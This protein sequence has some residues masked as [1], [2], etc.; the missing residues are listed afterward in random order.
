[1]ISSLAIPVRQHKRGVRSIRRSAS[2]A[3]LYVL[4]AIVFALLMLFEHS[5]S[6]ITVA[7]PRL[8]S[9]T[10]FEKVQIEILT[11]QNKLLTAL[12]TAL[13]AT[14]TGFLL[15]RE[16]TVSID[17]ADLVRAVASWTFAAPSL[18]LGHLGNRQLIW[19][20]HQRFFDPFY[21]GVWWSARGQ[22]WC[23]LISA[24]LLA[25]F[26]YRSVVRQRLKKEV[27]A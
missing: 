7:M 22:F 26:V 16:K 11:E 27:H 18:Y 8:E 21:G 6:M 15:N 13:I 12:A 9:I 24:A 10:D 19:M 20:V 17:N 4:L 5:L 1:M 3:T 2:A 14:V 25:D 23:F